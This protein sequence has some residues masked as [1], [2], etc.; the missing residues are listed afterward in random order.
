MVSFSVPAKVVSSVTPPHALP[1][2]K[3]DVTTAIVDMR[4]YRSLKEK[5]PCNKINISTCYISL[6]CDISLFCF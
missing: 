6:K 3:Y 5:W 4:L 1:L 2:F